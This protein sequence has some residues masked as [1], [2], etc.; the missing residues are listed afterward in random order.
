MYSPD[1]LLLPAEPEQPILS[2]SRRV[3]GWGEDPI[4]IHF[5]W[6]IAQD[7]GVEVSGNWMVNTRGAS[8]LHHLRLS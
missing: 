6:R 1:W 3:A 7:A 8:C 5:L 4:S 2:A